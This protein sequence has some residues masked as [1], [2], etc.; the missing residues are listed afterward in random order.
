M[1]IEWSD[2]FTSTT[3]PIVGV[4]G[5]DFMLGQSIED[6]K[7]IE[8][9]DM[10]TILVFAVPSGSGSDTENTHISFKPQT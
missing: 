4:L 3:Q 7:R 6:R 2:I 5:Q 8:E 1:Q 10:K 9:T